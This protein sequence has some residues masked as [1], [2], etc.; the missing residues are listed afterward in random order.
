MYFAISRSQGYHSGDPLPDDEECPER[1]SR[2]HT[3]V[4]GEW[5]LI[6]GGLKESLKAQIADLENANLVTQRALRETIMAHNAGFSIIATLLQQLVPVGTPPELAQI[7]NAALAQNAKIQAV[8][9]LIAAL[10]V[11]INQVPE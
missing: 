6:D 4:N 2:F 11:Q 5:V 9:S 3:F 1:P 7:I 10:R 8:E